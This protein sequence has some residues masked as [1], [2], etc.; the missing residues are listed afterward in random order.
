MQG[1][2]ARFVIY[3]TIIIDNLQGGQ[4]NPEL[5]AIFFLLSFV[6]LPLLLFI[7]IYQE[8]IFLILLIRHFISKCDIR[9]FHRI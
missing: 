7:Y 6:F 4:A 8:Y 2:G 5:Y 1:Y 9:I 3:F